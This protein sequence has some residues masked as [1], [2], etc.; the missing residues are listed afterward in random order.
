M[1]RGIVDGMEDDD[2][3]RPTGSASLTP[4]RTEALCKAPRWYTSTLVGSFW[5]AA[6]ATA[7]RALKASLSEDPS[8]DRPQAASMAWAGDSSAAPDLRV[9]ARVFAASASL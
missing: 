6:D 3:L 5:T 9:A 1:K 7:N 2:V 4:E 8:R